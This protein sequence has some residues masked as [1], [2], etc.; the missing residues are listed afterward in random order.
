M[1][2]PSGSIQV[3]NYRLNPHSFQFS[4]L[5]NQQ[6]LHPLT[7]AA[8][9]AACAPQPNPSGQ[10]FF[11]QMYHHPQPSHQFI[12]PPPPPQSFHS[13]FQPEMEKE[14]YFLI[15]N[16]QPTSQQQHHHHHQQQQLYHHPN[17]QFIQNTS[18]PLQLQSIGNF[19]T[20]NQQEFQMFHN[21]HHPT[22]LNTSGSGGGNNQIRFG[23]SSQS[24]GN[25]L[26]SDLGP[27]KPLM[28]QLKEP[29]SLMKKSL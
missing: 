21:H 1:P 29:E 15:V 14:K 3:G 28:S 11:T 10:P 2:S 7:I 9:A 23:E 4:M 5:N 20:S 17:M 8:A 13:Q 6:S 27:P 26:G 19:G 24:G 16:K 25:V 12:P 22:V 18:S